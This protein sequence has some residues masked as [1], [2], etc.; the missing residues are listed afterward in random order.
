MIRGAFEAHVTVDAAFARD[1]FAELCRELGA[2][3]LLI[4]LARGAHPTQPM[5]STHHT[6]DVPSVLAE[7]RALEQR[8]AAAGFAVARVKIEADVT[9]EGIPVDA[10]G[11]PGTYFEFHAKLHVAKDLDRLRELCI[12]HRAHLS[13][14]E[15]SPKQG[16]IAPGAR[17][18]TLRVYEAG[19]DR[20]TA[21]FANLVEALVDAGYPVAATKAEFTLHDSRVELDA[22]WLP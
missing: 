2:K 22:G 18:V 5:T 20:A 13:R 15:L 4:E 7:V 3:C 14:N 1:A 10:P 21:V 11:A 8:I 16:E 12:A 19:R 17:F 6:G 9:N